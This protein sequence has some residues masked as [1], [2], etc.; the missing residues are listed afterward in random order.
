MSESKIIDITF[1]I[2]DT[3]GKEFTDPNIYINEW[4][5]EQ[6]E[7]VKQIS[8]QDKITPDK[9]KYIGGMD[10]SFS[11]NDSN[12]ASA[13]LIIHNYSTLEIVARF[14]TN[15]NIYVPYKAGYLAFREVP[16]LLKLLEKVKQNYPEYVP[17]LIIMDGNGIYHYRYCGL[18]SHFSVLSGIPCIGISKNVLNVNGI[19]RQKMKDLINKH[20]PNKGD[21]C[22]IIDNTNRELGYAYN[23]TG[24]ANKAVYVSPGSFVSMSSC[25]IISKHMSKYRINESV[26]QADLL[27]RK[28]C[29]TNQY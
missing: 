6:L 19:N 22:K 9:I 24:N 27:S 5:T 29:K 18:A 13:C 14:N 20:A 2:E 10:I 26:R 25:I 4:N 17:D 7:I 16:T 15:C 3:L 12:K 23:V 28:L 11:P 1:T 21:H 8:L